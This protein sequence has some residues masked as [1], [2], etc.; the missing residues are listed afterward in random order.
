MFTIVQSVD[1]YI[2]SPI[3]AYN[4]G[5][6]TNFL[7]QT[8][9][10]TRGS[11]STIDTLF[12]DPIDNLETI[13]VD[14]SQDVE[15][16]LEHQ[17]YITIRV[18]NDIENISTIVID[19]KKYYPVNSTSFLES[20]FFVFDF[21]TQE[22]RLKLAKSSSQLGYQ[23]IRANSIIT[24]TA[25]RSSNNNTGSSDINNPETVLKLKKNYI[26]HEINPELISF[27]SKWN[28]HG[29]I[30]ISRSLNE[31]AS[32]SF[33][34]RTCKDNRSL[35]I[36]SLANGTQFTAFNLKWRI[37][38]LSITEKAKTNG[39]IVNV[40]CR[41]FLAP[42]GNP[43]VS[44]I[45][46][47]VRLAGS[48]GRTGSAG[49]AG[50]TTS[51]LV[52]ASVIAKKVGI[53]YSGSDI[54]IRVPKEVDV[55]DTISLEEILSQRAIVVLG[56]PFY[57]NGRGV[58]VRKWNQGKIHIINESEIRNNSLN[59]TYNGHG[60]NFEG[61]KL[62]TEYRNLKIDLDFNSEDIENDE[63]Q[64]K[65][66]LT[67]R[68]SF[69]NCQSL[70]DLVSPREYR[71]FYYTTPSPDIL[72][73]PGNTFDNGGPTKAATQI[74]ELN[75]TVVFEY[76]VEYGY[77]FSSTDVYF[78][79]KKSD[80]SSSIRL[81]PGADPTN[82]WKKIK[83]TTTDYIYDGDGYLISIRTNG[84]KAARL[85]QES[86][87]LE[88]INLK[89]E[90]QGDDSVLSAA[91]NI[92][93]AA[94]DFNL[95]LRKYFPDTVERKELCKTESAL[96]GGL[97]GKEKDIPP[98]FVA[99]MTR[100]SKNE[101]LTDNPKNKDDKIYPIVI[102]GD[103]TFE[104]EI[105]NILSTTRPYKFETRIFSQHSQGTHFKNTIALGRTEQSI[106]KPGL[107]T[108]LDT[109][110]VNKNKEGSLNKRRYSKSEFY[111]N[112]PGVKRGVFTPEGSKLYPDVTNPFIARKISEVELSMINTQQSLT[113][114][115]EIDYRSN[116]EEGDFVFFRGKTWK[117]LQIQ[118]DILFNGKKFVN[119]NLSLKLGYYLTPSLNLTTKCNTKISEQTNLA[120]QA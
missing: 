3:E 120:Q 39:I 47:K 63:E 82:Y 7:I 38:R 36:T 5:A 76:R 23:T 104:Q 37:E 108:R 96:N 92:Q 19:Q 45:N 61:V 1:H 57:T 29:V 109:T 111:L 50:R 103:F 107:A 85:L 118:N 56:F 117:I 86:D 55:F 48:L 99:S 16:D 65:N 95:K 30:S 68:W 40:T 91:D 80:G 93:L 4:N 105:T 34:F 69:E 32:L 62:H 60:K 84:T 74:T 18:D 41:D 53:S 9:N 52:F 31:H 79:E 119:K 78:E 83:E 22:I 100:F 8:N 2:P 46:T 106:G 12:F 114:D 28:A 58:E 89:I 72:R 17:E 13:L 6:H 70:A 42:A 113:I 24:I 115:L 73:S 88:A 33:T 66:G 59:Y 49:L 54:A 43:S 101:I 15:A 11:L 97:T 25:S 44:P 87:S 94:Y 102:T 71:S 81:N 98:K 116:L 14:S 20:G 27:L 112:S 51:K 75:G 110:V 26:C 77:A 64:D 90:L 21:D 10:N 35:V 67:K